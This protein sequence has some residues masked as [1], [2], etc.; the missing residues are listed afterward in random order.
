MRVEHVEQ[1]CPGPVQFDAGGPDEALVHPELSHRTCQDEG[2]F[3]DLAD[4]LTGRLGGTPTLGGIYLRHVN[5]IERVVDH[6]KTADGSPVRY[7]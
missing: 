7:L 3:P 5:I 2:R 4:R 1:G 6:D